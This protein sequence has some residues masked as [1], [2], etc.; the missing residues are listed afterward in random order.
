MVHAVKHALA[1]IGNNNLVLKPKAASGS[2]G[3]LQWQRLFRMVPYWIWQKPL[4]PA[5]IHVRL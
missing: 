5:A 3:S 1:C 2:G 4:L